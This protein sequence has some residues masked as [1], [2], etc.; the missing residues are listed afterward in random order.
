MDASSSCGAAPAALEFCF[1]WIDWWPF[2]MTKAEWSG[3]VQ[4]FGSIGALVGVWLAINAQRAQALEVDRRAME[5][6][7]AAALANAISGAAAVAA[8]IEPL[9]EQLE[10]IDLRV[11]SMRAVQLAEGLS[12][13]QAVKLEDLPVRKQAAV[14]AL[15]SMATAVVRCIEMVLDAPS[16]NP[17]LLARSV[18]VQVVRDQAGKLPK[19]EAMLNEP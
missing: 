16:G 8:V 18:L 3:W 13:L 1:L 7:T 2:C 9:N 5:R 12:V 14:L 6:A 10:G 11:L 17:I 4:A 19:N 15:R